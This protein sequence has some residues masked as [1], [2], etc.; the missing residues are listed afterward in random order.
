MRIDL[1]VDEDRVQWRP[2][3]EAVERAR[4]VVEAAGPTDGVL[5]V[6]LTGDDYV[7][8]L[9]LRYR[10]KDKATDVLSFSYLE[11]HE[12][13]RGALLRGEVKA[14]ECSDDPG[15]GEVLVGQVLIS[16]ASLRARELRLDHSDDEEFVFLVAHGLLHTLGYD[17]GDAEEASMMEAAQEALLRSLSDGRDP[18][19]RGESAP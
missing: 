4:R 1:A 14:R 18:V 10:N 11:D 8:E 13:Q 17:H 5:E 15:E 16:E 19:P 2:S 7:H 6:V 12:A 3:P 9:N